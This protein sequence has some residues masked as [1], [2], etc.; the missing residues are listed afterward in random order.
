[1]QT[2]VQGV[3]SSQLCVFSLLVAG[4]GVQ[5]RVPLLWVA[6]A[7]NES[8]AIAILASLGSCNWVGFVTFSANSFSAAAPSIGLLILTEWLV[9]RKLLLADKLPIVAEYLAF[10]R[11]QIAAF[12]TTTEQAQFEGTTVSGENGKDSGPRATESE[13]NVEA[14]EHDQLLRSIAGPEQLEHA[15]VGMEMGADSEHVLQTSSSCLGEA[16]LAISGSMRIRL[17]PEQDTHELGQGFSPV[18]QAVPD[19]EFELSDE[20][21]NA[22]ILQLSPLGFRVQVSRKRGST[23]VIA[24]QIDWYAFESEQ[25]QSPALP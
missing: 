18:F 6:K 14:L 7:T 21:L 5:L 20:N 4:F 19:I 1:M 13:G 16:G 23:G 25:A 17:E 2:A 9:T 3:E 11:R 10:G 24:C 22:K 12:S 15:G 8:Q